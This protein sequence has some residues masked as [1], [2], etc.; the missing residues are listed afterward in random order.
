M[1]QN[2]GHISPVR[3]QGLLPPALPAQPTATSLAGRESGNDQGVD[4]VA[5]LSILSADDE[6]RLLAELG[7]IRVSIDNQTENIDQC[8]NW[9]ATIEEVA[10]GFAL[11]IDQIRTRFEEAAAPPKSMAVCLS[12]RAHLDTARTAWERRAEQVLEDGAQDVQEQQERGQPPAVDGITPIQEGIAQGIDG[13][14]LPLHEG[15]LN[16]PIALM[17]IA[18]LLMIAVLIA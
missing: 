18:L 12:A 9:R 16:R 10:Q 2:W 11:R 6:A 1:S 3:N 15:G 13:E 7:Q 4:N 14:A 8:S 17:L 5:A